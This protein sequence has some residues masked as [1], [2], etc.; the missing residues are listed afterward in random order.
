M[1]SLFTVSCALW[2][3]IMSIVAGPLKVNLSGAWVFLD[4]RIGSSDVCQIIF[5]VRDLTEDV[6]ITSIPFIVD[7]SCTNLFSNIESLTLVDYW[8]LGYPTAS[9]LTGTISKI[10]LTSN[11]VCMVF[12]PD[13]DIV[14]KKG[15]WAGY[16][17]QYLNVRANLSTNATGQF[18]IREYQPSW[19]NNVF[20]IESGTQVSTTFTKPQ[21]DSW[22]FRYYCGPIYVLG[23]DRAPAEPAKIIRQSVYWVDGERQVQLNFT[24]DPNRPYHMEESADL[25]HWHR[26]TSN[27][28]DSSLRSSQ[29]SLPGG[30]PSGKSS[31][32]FQIITNVPIQRFYRIVA[33][34]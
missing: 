25:I 21:D 1:K 8:S 19:T 26:G 22:G 13:Q 12:L 9:Y 29:Q 10:M 27:T 7:V 2:C 28:N 24:G 3:T 30:G 32:G 15:G 18:Y 16:G 4:T 6:R 20:G 33:D 14:I 17:Y 5:D 31:C 11:R 34:P 23:H